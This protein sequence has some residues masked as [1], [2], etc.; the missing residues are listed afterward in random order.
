MSVLKDRSPFLAS[1][2]RRSLYKVGITIFF[3]VA[4]VSCQPV[5]DTP[6]QE[7]GVRV[8]VSEQRLY[9]VGCQWI[10]KSDTPIKEENWK[11]E[12]SM[13][14]EEGDSIEKY[15]HQ[16]K[17]LE[18][19]IKGVQELKTTKNIDSLSFSELCSKES[20]VFIERRLVGLRK[21]DLEIKESQIKAQL[22]VNRVLAATYA[23]IAVNSYQ[24]SM[25]KNK[26]ECLLPSQQ[27]ACEQHDFLTRYK[28]SLEFLLEYDSETSKEDKDNLKEF[29]AALQ[30]QLKM[31]EP[32]LDPLSK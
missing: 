3:A 20:S 28:A 4:A 5:R 23:T 21:T 19:Y 6:K 10:D 8:I 14:C 12:M 9:E 13:K 18:A 11:S 30:I 22:E 7:P 31:I 16:I 32:L 15:D 29:I 26:I 17:I 2:I 24:C 27:K 25:S 1:N